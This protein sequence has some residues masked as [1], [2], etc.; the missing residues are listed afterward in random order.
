MKK[1]ASAT[2]IGL[3]VVG[4]LV[5]LVAGVILAGGGRLF[6]HK[7]RVVMHFS[8]SIY[9]LQPGAPVVF[10]GVRL[11]SVSSIGLAYDRASDDF[12]IPV[13]AELESA[14]IQG[15]SQTRRGDSATAL[16][17]LIDRGMTA[18]LSMQSLLT[19]Q[20]YVDLDLRPQKDKEAVQRGSE[21]EMLE[22]P[23]TATAIQALKN[24][25]D[26]LDFRQLIDDV[27]AIA[28]SARAV[29]AGPELKKALSDLAQITEH[30]RRL[31][32][33]VEARFDPLADAT[34]ATLG[35]ARRAVRQVGSAADEV[36]Q[37]A[38]RLG[39]AADGV[40][41]LVAPD[42]ALILKLQA[43]LGEVSEMA[44][45]LRQQAGGDSGLV[46]NAN[47]ALHD[48]SRAARSMRELAD[49]LERHPEALLRGRGAAAPQ[50]DWEEDG[51]SAGK[52]SW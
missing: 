1:K 12:L 15:L 36:G 35:D 23:T 51:D 37:T 31:A 42:S 41:A 52:D 13:V 29:V 44:G 33:R 25:I 46:Q 50:R 20:L 19:G 7:E 24:Q 11:G 17:A 4:G 30:V 16:V 43:T 3:F 5:L 6:A 38:K 39:G 18:Q 21:G 49:L 48:V 28:G 14:S 8:G 45:S 26:G 2:T 9:G 32:E 34:T 10:R 27:S 47:Q 22:I 40:S